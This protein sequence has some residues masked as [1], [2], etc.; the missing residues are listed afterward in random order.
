MQFSQLSVVVAFI[1]VNFSFDCEAFFNP[2]RYGWPVPNADCSLGG[3]V[4]PKYSYCEVSPV[5]AYALCCPDYCSNGEDPIMNEY[6]QP[7]H[8]GR[9]GTRCP[10]GYHCI[11]APNDAWA[12]CCANV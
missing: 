12:V 5:D 2:C 6:R 11:T 7:I 9:G 1:C 4:C 8:C 3:S 10:D